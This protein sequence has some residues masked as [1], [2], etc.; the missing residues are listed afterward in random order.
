M[1]FQLVCSVNEGNN[2]GPFKIPLPWQRNVQGEID[3]SRRREWSKKSVQQGRSLFDARSVPPVRE[4]GKMATCLR[5]A[6]RRRQGTPLAAFFNI[7][8]MRC[9]LREGAEVT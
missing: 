4:H 5:E 8:T 6:L 3:I 1:T 2:H 9:D 7:P